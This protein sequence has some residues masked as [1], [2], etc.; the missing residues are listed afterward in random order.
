[1][2]YNFDRF[3]RYDEM[4][5]WLNDAARR[6][7]SLL[8]V[9]SY[10]KSHLGRSLMLATITDST[11]GTHDTKPAHW[12]DAN[13]HATEVT[14]GVA[15]LYVIQYLLENFKTDRHVREALSTR[16]FYIAPRVNPDGVEDALAD[17]PQFHRSS[18]RPWPWRDGFRWPGLHIGD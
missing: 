15:A 2:A 12:I 7:P 18:V 6:Y 11:T 8:T 4:V 13:I 16:T 3:L 1:M 10:G 9:E 14:G 5:D 17:S